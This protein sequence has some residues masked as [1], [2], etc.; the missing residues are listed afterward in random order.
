MLD[1]MPLS[2]VDFKKGM[3]LLVEGKR[4]E[5]RFFII[6]DGY[7]KITKQVTLIKEDA[8][9]VIGPGDFIGIVPA[10]AQ[11]S[12]IESAQALT[13]V[14]VLAVQNTQFE[15][16]IQNNASV[17]MKI[18]QQFSRRIRYLNN[19]LTKIASN[20]AA[21]ETDPD[22]LFKTGE[23][24]M[25]SKM[26]QQACYVFKRYSE[27]YPGGKF[28]RQAA[29]YMETLK[30]FDEAPF[31]SGSDDFLHTYNKNKIIFANGEPGQSLYIIQK[32]SVKITKILN[33]NEIILAILKHGDIFGE[34]A[35]L[36]NKPRSASA[37]AQ[38][39]GTVL[40][41]VLKRN[42]DF[43]AKTQPAIINRLTQ[44]LSERIW[45]GYK[46]QTNALIKDPLGRTYNYMTII[47]EKNNVPLS[48]NSFVF[49]FGLEELLKMAAVPV[50]H[51]KSVI[52]QLLND[53]SIE[54]SN[55]K[56]AIRYVDEIF[57]L[58]DYHERLHKREAAQ[59]RNKVSH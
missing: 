48:A 42:F 22:V 39:N 50:E 38:E 18:I 43:I 34:M 6:R 33:S 3:Y 20:S 5:K 47:L 56:L 7:V 52:T 4:D 29:D 53:K 27:C 26:N 13:D 44:M 15:G 30:A 16:L 49:D 54:L 58:G 21:A 14:T 10:M 11:R 32:G 46:Q 8:E 51:R 9:S 59:N 23:Y 25:N 24:Y 37:I 1:V 2:V 36:E 17:A 19:A 55:G 45:F 57:K 40:M 28:A 12:Q 35:L 31:E 41:E